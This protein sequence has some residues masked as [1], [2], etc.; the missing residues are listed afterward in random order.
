[1]PCPRQQS[2]LGRGRGHI[3]GRIQLTREAG[4]YC[5][6][7]SCISSG[8]V[9]VGCLANLGIRTEKNDLFQI[10]S[11]INCQ[12]SVVSLGSDM[13][14]PTQYD[15]NLACSCVARFQISRPCHPPVSFHVIFSFPRGFSCLV[16]PLL[17][18]ITNL[19]PTM[20]GFEQ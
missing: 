15:K 7:W 17:R 1:M 4:A 9:V 6:S 12:T 14:L 13:V 5:W 10:L 18:G 11:A 19:A 16:G 20:G 2:L 8:V 3:H